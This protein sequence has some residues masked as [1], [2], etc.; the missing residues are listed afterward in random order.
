M[1][2]K[3]EKPD[4][5]TWDRP[6]H[7]KPR[8]HAN[9]ECWISI[10]QLDRPPLPML[11]EFGGFLGLDLVKGITTEETKAKPQLLQRAVYP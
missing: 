5:D 10:E 9:D 11:D 6:V 8:Q 3:S 7:F 2:R 1:T 4:T